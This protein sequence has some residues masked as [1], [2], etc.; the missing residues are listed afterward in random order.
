MTA[1]LPDDLQEVIATVKVKACE[2]GNSGTIIESSDKLFLPAER[3]VFASRS[4]SRTEEFNALQRWQYYAQNDTQNARK[5]NRH[6]S[7][8]NWWL[9]SPRGG[10][11]N[12][13]AM[14]NSY[15]NADYGIAIYNDGVAP[16]F[17]I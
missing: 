1:L 9:R 12:N 3:E 4:Y 6:G 5:K 7:A 14:V 13:F 17:C 2:S 15:G 16:G 10:G 8:S 11:S